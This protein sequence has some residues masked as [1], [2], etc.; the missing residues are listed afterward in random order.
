[1][2][3]IDVR[4]LLATV[5]ETCAQA[6]HAQWVSLGAVAHGAGSSRPTAIIDPEAL[7]LLS[8]A[9]RDHDPRLLERV[10]WWATTASRLMSVQRM[11]SLAGRFPSSR[12]TNGLGLFAG[13]ALEA[14]DRRWTAHATPDRSI[15]ASGRR[16]PS[17]PVFIESSTLWLRLRAG[18]GVGAKADTLAFLMGLKGGRARV[19]AISRATGYTTTAIRAAA[20]DM[21]LARLI[22]STPS[23]PTEYFAPERAWGELLELYPLAGAH[24]KRPQMPP[25]RF[26]AEVFALLAHVSVG[27]ERASTRRAGGR[28]MA[29]WGSGL[30]EQHRAAFD[31]NAI[32]IPVASASDRKGAG[33]VAALTEAIRIMTVWL[34]GNL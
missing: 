25:W 12:G 27:F 2:Q 28:V 14:G 9:L 4:E 24:A 20:R 31:V 13:L 6:C 10:A 8:I 26:W 7:V 29:S 18:L 19:K 3:P 11:R 5:R 1:M 32:R 22:R 16:G 15:D 21:A 33:E 34:E 17:S 23:H 30:I